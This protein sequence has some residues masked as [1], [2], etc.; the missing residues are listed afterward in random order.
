MA[1]VNFLEK[2]L[3]AL[4]Y[5]KGVLNGSFRTFHKVLSLLFAGSNLKWKTLHFSVFLSEPIIRKNPGSQVIGQN[6]LIQ[7]DY[8]IL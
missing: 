2:F 4:K 1:E 5:T 3:F 6:T 7:L 8:R